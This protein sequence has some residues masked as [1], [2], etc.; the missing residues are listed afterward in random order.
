LFIK[1]KKE[2]KIS[3]S[4]AHYI[5]SEALLLLAQ[6]RVGGGGLLG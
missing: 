5:I 2:R 6:I 4:F 1:K 3:V